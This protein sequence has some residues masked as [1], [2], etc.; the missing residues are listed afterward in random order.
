MPA[1]AAVLASSVIFAAVHL[2]PKDFPQL[3]GLGL[4]LGFSYVRTRNLLTPLLVHS[5]WNT[6][7]LTVLT[8]LSA[9]GADMQELL[10]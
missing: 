4:V 8:A 2:A 3:L 6:G 10:R 9:Q 7:V 5:L 1:P